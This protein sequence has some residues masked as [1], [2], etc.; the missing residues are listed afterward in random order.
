MGEF[1]RVCFSNVLARVSAKTIILPCY[2]ITNGAILKTLS[3]INILI[4]YR[5]ACHRLPK[6]GSL[7]DYLSLYKASSERYSTLEIAI[8]S[9]RGKHCCDFV[10]W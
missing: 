9:R 7:K 10:T 2:L 6:P 8:L 3:K 4:W 5:M 1:F